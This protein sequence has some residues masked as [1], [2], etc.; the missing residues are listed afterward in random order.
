[1]IVRLLGTA[2]GG[3]LPQ[4]NCGCPNCR[5]S[6]V[7]FS[8]VAARTQASAAVSG[9]GEQWFLLNVSP[10]VRIQI[11][12]FP[13]LHPR[14]LR[15]TPLGGVVLT[16][17]DIDACLGLFVLREDQALHVH[18]TEAVERGLREHNA[19]VRTLERRAG[20]TAWKRLRCGEVQPLVGA[21]GPSGLSIELVSVPG[22]VPLHLKQLVDP[23]PDDNVAVVLRD[24]GG[25]SLVY[26]PSV[27]RHCAELESR[28]RAADVLVFDGTFYR[29][30][31][32]TT[33]GLTTRSA[34]DMAHWPLG[35]PEGSLRFLTQMP[36]SHKI[37]THINNTNPVL[38]V[39]SPERAA[40]SRAGVVVG[41]DG[42]EVRL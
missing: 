20:H 23:S 18:A 2:A 29:D 12:S 37:L 4:W 31:E 40:V 19:L 25:R 1:V 5:G 13:A 11:D 26:A 24:A 41:H 33:L 14:A 3:G 27:G 16:N 21:A 17:G 35:G 7:P 39:S 6:R 22:T 30:D 38:W 36:C 28:A 15:D 10:D 34:R 42:L 9:D 8:P 32:L